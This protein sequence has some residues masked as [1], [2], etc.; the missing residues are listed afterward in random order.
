MASA[1]QNG[2]KCFYLHSYSHEQR[3]IQRTETQQ[4]VFIRF[5][6]RPVTFNTYAVLLTKSI[7]SLFNLKSN[8]YTKS[9]RRI[10]KRKI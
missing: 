4:Y 5:N 10:R 2:G 6:G 9:D 7:S 1:Q 3:S 8:N